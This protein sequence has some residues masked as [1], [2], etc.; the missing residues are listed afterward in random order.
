M[1]L[2]LYMR[3]D[4]CHLLSILCQSSGSSVGHDLCCWWA[5]TLGKLLSQ[6]LSW[7]IYKMLGVKLKWGNIGLDT[8]VVPRATQRPFPALLE[9][10]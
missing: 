10:T 5:E 4:F 2:S 3:F 9:W 6:G 8:G 7:L 1:L